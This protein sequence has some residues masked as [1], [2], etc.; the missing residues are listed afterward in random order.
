M[1]AP[2]LLL[3]LWLFG[4]EAYSKSEQRLDVNFQIMQDRVLTILFLLLSLNFLAFPSV[5]VHSW[6]REDMHRLNFHRSILHLIFGTNGNFG[7]KMTDALWTA[8]MELEQNGHLA[9]D[10]RLHH[11]F[12]TSEDAKLALE[13][14]EKA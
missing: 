5:P 2:F 14:C 13:I 3:V 12:K 1:V 9:E 4:A 8:R 6:S 7:M 10:S 11:Y